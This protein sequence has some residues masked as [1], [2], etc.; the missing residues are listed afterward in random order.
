[1][2][3]PLAE[4]FAISA[5]EQQRIIDAAAVEQDKGKDLLGGSAVN[6]E[7]FAECEQFQGDYCGHADTRQGDRRCTRCAVDQQQNDDHGNQ[8]DEK[9]FLVAALGGDRVV[10]SEP[11]R[12]GHRGG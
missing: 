3:M 4:E 9:R 5:H 6:A 12:A 1:M 8:R 11:G 10:V 2:G 7:G